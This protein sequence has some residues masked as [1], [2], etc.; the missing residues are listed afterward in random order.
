MAASQRVIWGFLLRLEPPRAALFLQ[1]APASAS[2]KMAGASPKRLASSFQNI[3]FEPLSPG[4][5]LM[6]TSLPSEL[7][8][9]RVEERPVF[10]ISIR[11][12]G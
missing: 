7:S 10:E 12:Y 8:V 11:S 6:I 3:G 9:S 1:N 2:Q 4:L 5:I